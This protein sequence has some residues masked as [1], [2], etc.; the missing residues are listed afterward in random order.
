M[1]STIFIIICLA[2]YIFRIIICL[3]IR[4]VIGRNQT[5]QEIHGQDN[6]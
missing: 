1:N 6:S 5:D 2:V 3:F 4:E